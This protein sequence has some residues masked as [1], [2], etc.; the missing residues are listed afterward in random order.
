MTTGKR[1][2]KEQPNL[3]RFLRQSPWRMPNGVIVWCYQCGDIAAIV[4]PTLDHMSVS[5]PG[6]YPTWDEIAHA[7][8]ALLPAE[9]TYG[10]M[11]PPEQEYVNEDNGAENGRGGNIFHLWEV[12]Y[13]SPEARIG[14]MLVRGL[15]SGKAGSLWTA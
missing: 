11:L 7:R 14:R 4:D 8:Y 2:P 3:G 13:D 5:T 1:T 15:R 12:K 6:R 10:F 9:R